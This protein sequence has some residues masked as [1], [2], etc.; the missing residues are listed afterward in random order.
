M[1]R[2][3]EKE[4][5]MRAKKT[6]II[7]CI[8]VVAV[9]LGI[10]AYFV[11]ANNNEN[12]Q[13]NVEIKYQKTNMIT[14]FRLGISDFDN[15]N[16][17]LTKNRDIIQIDSLIFEPL[18]TITQDYKISNCLAKEWSKVSDNAYVIKLKEN[19]KWQDGN[20]FT[21]N[22]VKFTIETIQKNK[23]SIYLENVKE[24]E[25]I[26]VVDEYT[27]RL[28]L[29]NEIP[30]FEYQLIF[31]IL[32]K[33]QYEKQDMTKS[34]QIPLGTGMYKISKIGKETIE[35][36]QNDN[37]H[38]IENES[39]N[40]KNISISIFETMG[41]VYNSFRL[42]N[43]DLVNTSNV[44]YEEYIGSI[45]YQKK[46]Y[47]GREYDY[48]S[49]NCK[50]AIL[51]NIE[52]RQAIQ[53]IINK[54][55]IVISI[56]ENHAYASNFPLD[57]G[58]YILENV[59]FSNNYNL[60]KASNILKDNGWNYEYGIWSKEIDGRTRTLN[61]NITVNK[62]N[63]NRVKVAKEIKTQLEEFGIHV[64][65]SELSNSDYQKILENHNY[66]IL[67]TGMYS[68]Y[69]PELN[70]LLGTNN[71]ANYKNEEI[72]SILKQVTNMT[73]DDLKKESYQK[74][75]DIYQKEV[76]YI[77]LYRNQVTLAYGQSVR[78]EIT[79]NNYNIFYH[80]NEWYRQ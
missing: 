71:L 43:I 2:A 12:N 80:F 69:S 70:T 79:P 72:D 41:E 55:K 24:I 50:N 32:S 16:P 20:D 63:S 75:V 31:P 57:Y 4:I 35:L 52:V 9:L 18:L 3:R 22:D 66:E 38:E 11:Y 74:I 37:W 5:I 23:K 44:K 13:E 48:L 65:I 60:E 30:F 29:K 21:A 36:T 54:E 47:T 33:K 77:G 19:V 39:A 62:E 28:E 64:T 68:G 8:I 17:H 78:G 58:S 59:Q 51:K 67:L 46:Q 45:G 1:I 61:F 6:K 15:M 49:L 73:S 76:P 26:E 10:V 7:L 25:T 40:I 53:N 42:G 14:N 34:T 56:L 27:I